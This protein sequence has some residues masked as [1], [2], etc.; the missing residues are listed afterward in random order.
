METEK[1]PSFTGFFAFRGWGVKPARR[2][3]LMRKYLNRIICFG[4][5]LA[6][7]ATSSLFDLTS[8]YGMSVIADETGTKTSEDGKTEIADKGNDMF[9]G[10][11]DV[12]GLNKE[13]FRS[14]SMYFD[15]SRAFADDTVKY[16][17][18]GFSDD[19]GNYPEAGATSQMKSGTKVITMMQ[20]VNGNSVGFS[21]GSKVKF[22]STNTDVI[23]IYDADG[24]TQ[25]DNENDITCT[26]IRK[27]PGT[28]TIVAIITT[29]DT[30]VVFQFDVQVSF[31][32]STEA[33]EW[34]NP[35]SI[36]AGEADR[37]LILD[38][39]NF[40][41][42]PSYTVD[43]MDPAY[44]GNR[45]YPLDIKYLD[46]SNSSADLDTIEALPGGDYNDNIV[47][48]HDGKLLVVGAGFTHVTLTTE[49]D[50]QKVDFYVIVKPRG[51]L[52]NHGTYWLDDAGDPLYVDEVTKILTG[53]SNFTLYTNATHAS[54]LIWTVYRYDSGYTSSTN[55]HYR[56]ITDDTFLTYSVSENSG[57]VNFSYV[58]AGSYKIVAKAKDSYTLAYNFLTYYVSVLPSI[59]DQTLYINVGDTYD[60]IKNSNIPAE[61]F[62]HLYS[63]DYGP[64]DGT[65]TSSSV[66]ELNSA[67]GTI[68]GLA[69]GTGKVTIRFLTDSLGAASRTGIFDPSIVPQTQLAGATTYIVN[70]ID[71]I[72]ISDSTLSNGSNPTF[73][74]YIGADY[75]LYANV[76]N[77]DYTIYWESA[78]E[79]I[80]KVESKSYGTA[81]I[82]GLKAGTTTVRAYQIIDGVEKNAYATIIVKN[83]IT[84]ITLDPS[85]VTLEVDENKTIVAKFDGDS[86]DDIVW[87]SSDPT[88]FSFEEGDTKG[89]S[90]I[91]KG[92][93]PGKALLTAINPDNIVCGYCEVTVVQNATG[94]KLSET[95][96]T[97]NQTSPDH[98]L[99]AYIT[100]DTADDA[101]VTWTSTNPKVVTVD[102]NGLLSVKGT[103]EATI[104]VQSISNPELV[105]YCAVKVLSSVKGIKFDEDKI[106]MYKGESYRL[107][108]VI[109]PDDASETSVKVT[110]FDPKVATAAVSTDKSIVIKGAGT[111]KTQIMIMTTD[112]NY[113]DLVE[114]TV[115]QVATAIKMD[116][117]DVTLGVG[118]YFDMTV[119]IT[120][121]DATD[122]ALTWESLNPTIANVS[123]SGRIGGVAEGDAVVL[124]R[125]ANG[126]MAYANVHVYQK[127]QSIRLDP[128]K[129][130]IDSGETISIAV[131]FDPEKTT[132]QEVVWTSSEPEVAVI[133]EAGMVTGLKGGVTVITCKTIDGGLSAFC[134]IYV[135][136]PIVTI[137]LDPDEYIL[138]IDESFTIKATISNEETASNT[139]LIWYSDDESVCVVD[140]F[141]KVT[142]VGYGTAKVWC[143]AAESD[144]IAYCKVQVVKEVESIKL[145]YS[146]KTIVV[147]HSFTLKAKVN[148]A[149]AD[150]Q[151]VNFVADDPSI[152]IVDNDGIV[153]GIKPGSTFVRANAKDNSGVYALCFVTVINEIPATGITVSDSEIYLLPGETKTITYT[154][155]PSNSTDSIKWSSS[156]EDI[157]SVSSSGKITAK[158]IGVSTVTIMTTSGKTATVTV[159]VLGLSRT[160]LEIPIY[161]QYSQLVLDGADPADVRW[162]VTD[163]TVCDIQNGVITA[164]KLGSTSVTATYNG[165]TI[166][167]TIKVVPK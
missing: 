30:T 163:I 121:K 68:T 150:Y 143:E 47:K 62:S 41:D 117:T 17:V 44:T 125:T 76:T 14:R 85:E 108:Y 48:Y 60:I 161:T 126:V 59:D 120:P 63:I 75:P 165:R 112:G 124:C 88:I 74:I 130:T 13:L 136:E 159:H 71:N 66:F 26:L 167:A 73:I 49:S 22:S 78:D 148:P 29:D 25:P 140:R 103:G 166:K 93:K 77:K 39:A 28:T 92:L 18:A 72:S 115:K 94:L 95:E 46:S 33:A 37:V 4:I 147:G 12:T 61:D 110:S 9:A 43:P 139:D 113:Y 89:T 50:D 45:N 86:N 145:N 107:A 11:F 20:L 52:E 119:S 155:K 111:G 82:T 2:V 8:T 34:G 10:L 81:Y 105:A 157:A 6:L 104:V 3:Y 32:I 40:L 162:D 101:S 134:L 55:D 137:T 87:I 64:D 15:S 99:Y 133:N 69:I 114:V 100:P 5:A 1:Y 21:T 97:L 116:Y 91:I 129:A 142:G 102:N 138:G 80:L 57:V 7:M 158:R 65:T 96:V 23:A 70:V 51:D 31:R 146:T 83:T 149:D 156:D 58:D 84:K 79:K 164:R 42:D 109:S 36:I 122:I 141:G 56:K 27:G 127:A 38:Q 123:S 118:E 135:E 144:A 154:I 160:Y 67:T 132:N 90:V 153:T 54:D 98:Q 35:G 24:T 19:E 53:V 152:V 128:E 106:E 151:T 131:I 16:T